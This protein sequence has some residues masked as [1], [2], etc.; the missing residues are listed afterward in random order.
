MG[1]DHAS[2][3]RTGQHAIDLPQP[4]GVVLL[5]PPQHL[6][7][8]VHL[9]GALARHVA[10]GRRQR[11][12]IREHGRPAPVREGLGGFGAGVSEG[13]QRLPVRLAGGPHLLEEVVGAAAGG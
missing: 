4:G 7:Q 2:A 6:A 12:V 11:L 3:Q 10:L 5:D 1:V 9:L 8:R 13:V